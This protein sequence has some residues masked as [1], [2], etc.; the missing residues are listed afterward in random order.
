MFSFVLAYLFLEKNQ[1]IMSALITTCSVL[2][3][4]N[5]DDVYFIIFMQVSGISEIP[6]GF[7]G[8]G[9]VVSHLCK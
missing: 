6:D 3:V 9:D 1:V 4:V 8:T 2:G 7:K 5:V